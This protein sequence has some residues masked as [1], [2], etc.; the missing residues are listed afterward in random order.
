MCLNSREVLKIVVW[1]CIFLERRIKREETFR[2]QKNTANMD[3]R[4]RL[5]RL[6]LETKFKEDER[7]PE[8]SID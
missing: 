2:P 4:L 7:S 1:I 5:A 6:M 3:F 8:A